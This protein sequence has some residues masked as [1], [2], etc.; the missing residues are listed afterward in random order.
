MSQL[1]YSNKRYTKQNCFYKYLLFAVVLLIDMTAFNKEEASLNMGSILLC[2]FLLR[3]L[4]DYDLID[5]NMYRIF[6][7]TD[8][9]L[10]LKVVV[11]GSILG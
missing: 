11:F 6:V 3:A 1:S 5:R 2:T 4:I 10:K 9:F 7:E 8:F